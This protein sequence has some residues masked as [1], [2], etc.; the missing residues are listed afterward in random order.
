MSTG[1]HAQ[2]WA[3]ELTRRRAL[4]DQQDAVDRQKDALITRVEAQ[5]QQKVEMKKL[6]E[7]RWRVA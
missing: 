3:W 1:Y 2:Y 6:F 5:V 7:I 4:F